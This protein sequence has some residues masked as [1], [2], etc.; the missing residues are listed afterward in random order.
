MINEI[1]AEALKIRRNN[2]SMSY[3]AHQN[4]E[5]DIPVRKVVGHHCHIEPTDIENDDC[6]GKTTTPALAGQSTLVLPLEYF[7]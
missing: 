6:I 2:N 3:I 1:T 4:I 5:K 7:K